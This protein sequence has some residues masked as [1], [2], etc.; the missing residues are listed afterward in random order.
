MSDTSAQNSSR[1]EIIGAVPMLEILLIEDDPD[2][3]ALIMEY[4]DLESMRCD[5]AMTGAAGLSLALDTAGI[6]YDCIILDLQLPVLDGLSVCRQLRQ[7][8]IM[9]PVLML[10]ARDRLEDKLEGFAHGADDYLCKPFE[11]QE[12]VARITVLANRRY[13][14]S[15]LRCDTLVMDVA[16]R[17]VTRD[18]RKIPLS[19]T[20]W[21]LLHV[22]LSASPRPVSRQKLLF[23]VWGDC[24]PDSDSLKVHIHHLRKS[25]DL[26]G[27]LPL[28][29][30]VPGH[31]Y[32]LCAHR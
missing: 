7:R 13:N 21:K 2:L 1:T 17:A 15:L 6:G 24:P 30:T 23:E 5:N 22:L 27:E 18:G 16:N 12:L 26:P 10:T 29:H 25:V 14:R 31:G 20:E 9:T 32:A 4:L 8:G 28:L 19:G 11:M 3:S